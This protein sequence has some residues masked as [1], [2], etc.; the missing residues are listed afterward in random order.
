MPKNRPNLAVGLDIGHANVKAVVVRPGRP[1]KPLS[2]HCLDCRAEGLLDSPE[3]V[4][5]A[6]PEW[7]G[8]LGLRKREFAVAIPQYLATVQISDFPPAAKSNLGEM[9]EYETQQVAGL[10]EEGF[11]HDYAEMPSGL[12]RQNPVVIGIA[13]NTVVDERAAEIEPG[14]INIQEFAL[15][16]IA[17]ANAYFSLYKKESRSS[18]PHLLLDIGYESS[19]LVVVAGRQILS[20][21]SLL[22]GSQRYTQAL[23]RHLDCS[24]EEAEQTKREADL[25][26]DGEDGPLHRA[27]RQLESEIREALDHWRSQETGDIGKRMF[28]EVCLSGGGARLNGLAQHFGR[29]Y[30][31]R[32]RV[33]GP[34]GAD[35]N[36][37]PQAIIAYGTALQG[38]GRAALPVSVTP[39]KV[40][41]RADRRASFGALCAAAALFVAAAVIAGAW[42]YRSL[43]SSQE[44]LTERIEELRECAD[45]IPKIERLIRLREHRERMV[46][47]IVAKANRSH[48]IL[49]ALEALSEVRGEKDWFIYLAD[50]KS[51]QTPDEGEDPEGKKKERD[52]R[53][54]PPRPTGDASL[55]G[56]PIGAGASEGTV[57]SE[58]FPNIVPVDEVS[59]IDALV[60]A[61]F[62]EYVTTKPYKYVRR[63]VN[64][65]NG[66]ADGK[67]TSHATLFDNV[68]LL[69]NPEIE[70]EKQL[71][72]PWRK[73]IDEIKPVED[74]F[75]PFFLKLPFARR[76]INLPQDTP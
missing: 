1:G 34:K 70:P 16:G 47:P 62:S 5:D 10:S 72:Y 7:L 57:S 59:T 25:D 2:S 41:Y 55:L 29:Q 27:T 33:I 37:N 75:K 6:I 11:I 46:L 45:L 44:H 21:S 18:S 28:E 36:P 43:R 69:P 74:R 24:E 73:R 4:L 39:P 61:G 26:A 17:L 52:D 65:L 50:Q 35:G 9:V 13:K 42:Q 23:A 58:E 38:A 60:A 30:G 14:G 19:T 48:R 53:R 54:R 3:S 20:V 12:G 66:E 64:R 49:D 76:P 67:N 68:D 40:A 63:M 31:C 56:F 22:F 32:A 51:Y 8:E 71:F 15:S